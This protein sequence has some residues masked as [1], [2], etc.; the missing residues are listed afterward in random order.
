RSPMPTLVILAAGF[1]RRFGG[2]KQLAPVGPQGQPLLWYA[3]QDARLAGFT[4]AVLVIR[5]GLEAPLRRQ[6][7]EAPLPIHFA[8]QQTRTPTPWGTGHA[9]L[10]A[11]PLLTESFMVINADDFYGRESYRIIAEFLSRP[12]SGPMA[13]FALAAFPLGATLSPHGPVNRAICQVDA[14]GYLTGLEERLGLVQESLRLPLDTPVSMNC[15]GFRPA[16]FPLLT[17]R[18]DEF[19]S[20]GYKE[21]FML[22]SEVA[23]LVRGGLARVRVLAA[24]GPW[25][26]LT[27][28]GDLE[29]LIA[30]LSRL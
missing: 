11:A 29:P 2:D 20:R 12:P 16:L 21:E 24:P 15:W 4:R 28:P 3:L 22:P 14:Y 13:E 10:A 5:D 30:H 25:F 19:S 23:A 9:L 1:G 27:H 8:T 7:N 18:F 26:G 17:A 6:L